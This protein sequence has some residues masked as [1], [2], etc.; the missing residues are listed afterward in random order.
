[1]STKCILDLSGL[2]TDAKLENKRLTF[3]IESIEEEKANEFT[4]PVKFRNEFKAIPYISALMGQNVRYTVTE[5]KLSFPYSHDGFVSTETYLEYH[6]KINTGQL[7][8]FSFN[9]K[10]RQHLLSPKFIV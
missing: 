1:M 4:I 5:E 10:Q 7:K 6:I 3:S 9:Y 2:I 8:D